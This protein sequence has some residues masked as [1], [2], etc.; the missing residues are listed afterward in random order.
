MEK[1]TEIQIKQIVSLT[2][3]RKYTPKQ[4]S[5]LFQVTPEI[6][7]KKLKEHGLSGYKAPPRNQLTGDS[8]AFNQLFGSYKKGAKRRKLPFELTEKEFRAL[9]KQDCYYCGVK[10][11]YSFKNR[12]CSSCYIY[13]GI[14]RIDTK[15][16]YTKENSRPCCKICNFAKG[17][18]SEDEFWM[19][20]KRIS[21]FNQNKLESMIPGF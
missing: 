6:I 21:D 13:N 8:A 19:W 17:Q 3:E 20:L 11:N 5:Y 7:N 9:T 12:S 10:P 2:Q 4:L 14:D 16:G 1:L 18:L 15:S